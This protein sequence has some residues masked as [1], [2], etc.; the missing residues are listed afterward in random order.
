MEVGKCTAVY[1]QEFPVSQEESM[2]ALMN[3][4]VMSIMSL[5][6]VNIVSSISDMLE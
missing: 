3:M 4:T 6:I 5:M 2:V 1:V